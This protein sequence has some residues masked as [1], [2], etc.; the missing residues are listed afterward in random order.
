MR[1][2]S[3]VK[4]T[5]RFGFKRLNSLHVFADIVRDGFKVAQ[6]LLRLI[7]NSLVL[8]NGAI[9]REIDGRWLGVQLARNALS[10]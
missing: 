4:I 6:D 8:Q 7:D 3:E 5:Y 10:L 2:N 9:M 1:G